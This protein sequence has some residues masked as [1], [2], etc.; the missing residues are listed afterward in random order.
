MTTLRI[1]CLAGMFLAVIAPGDAAA[2]ASIRDGA[3]QDWTRL[4]D[5]MMKISEAM[6]ADKFD[7]R[8]T[9]PERTWGEQILHVAE[10]NVNQIGRLGPKA[11]VSLF[12]NPIPRSASC[13][14]S[15]PATAPT[16]RRSTVWRCFT[17]SV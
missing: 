10:A 7:Y 6:P 2:Q 1:A 5:T 11:A 8:A 4:K 12:R 17:S 9:P 3:V 16:T 15:T 13:T 14:V